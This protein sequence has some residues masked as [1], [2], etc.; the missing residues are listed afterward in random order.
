LGLPFLDFAP[1]ALQ[2]VELPLLGREDV[3]DRV[4]EIEQNPG[5][6]S[7]ALDS[8]DR[9]PLSLAALHDGVGDGSRLNLRASGHD[10]KRVGENRAAADVDGDEIFALFLERGVA[11]DVD[12]FSD[13]STPCALEAE[14]ARRMASVRGAGSRPR[15]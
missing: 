11:D 12:Q 5:A 3:D 6:V 7:V 9:E 13:G 8:F 4:S 1:Q 10:C 2:V 15:P 14:K